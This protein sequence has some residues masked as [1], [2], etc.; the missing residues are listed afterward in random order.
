LAIE[1]LLTAFFDTS[2][3]LRPLIEGFL[4]ANG[5][6]LVAPLGVTAEMTRDN[7]PGSFSGPYVEAGQAVLVLGL[8]LIAFV[9]LSAWILRKRD[10]A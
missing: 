10:V 4:R 1:G 7:G 2:D 9:G 6:S 8:Y 3:L 5:Y